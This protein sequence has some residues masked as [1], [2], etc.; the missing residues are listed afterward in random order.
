[1]STATPAGG[2]TSARWGL[3]WAGVCRR[4]YALEAAW[5]SPGA[6]Y[7]KVSAGG[8]RYILRLDE[9]K[10][11]WTLES[12]LDGKELLARPDIRSSPP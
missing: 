9:Q 8:R 6:R 5:I 3:N 12:A 11:E 4:I 2:P 7:F 10:D 1:M